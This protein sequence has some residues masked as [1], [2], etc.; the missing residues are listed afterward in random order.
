M[1]SL[2]INRPHCVKD[3]CEVKGIHQQPSE[4][5]LTWRELPLPVSDGSSPQ[6]RPDTDISPRLLKYTRGPPQGSLVPSPSLCLPQTLW[7]MQSLWPHETVQSRKEGRRQTVMSWIW[8]KSYEGTKLGDEVERNWGTEPQ[9]DGQGKA[10]LGAEEHAR[11]RWGLQEQ[12]R[13]AGQAG[14]IWGWG[15]GLWEI[16]SERAAPFL[17]PWDPPGGCAVRAASPGCW[18]T[19]PTASCRIGTLV[20]VLL[21]I[22]SKSLYYKVRRIV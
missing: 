19:G 3:L 9:M 17:G 21:F 16:S 2:E 5:A 7:T 8:K 22:I 10:G 6:I 4:T 14:V 11:S 1:S 12:V 13:R 15:G 18:G 20:C